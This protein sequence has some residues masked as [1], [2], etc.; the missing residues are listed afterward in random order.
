M[1]ELKDKAELQGGQE[2]MKAQTEK[3]FSGDTVHCTV[4]T[5][6]KHIYSSSVHEHNSKELLF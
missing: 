4:Y 2:H 3:I 1:K 5:V 6:T